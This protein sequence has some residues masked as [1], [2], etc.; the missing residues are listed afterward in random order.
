MCHLATVT[1][2]VA[3]VVLSFFASAVLGAG[4]LLLNPGAEQGKGDQPSV[5]FAA[6][7]PADGLRMN[8]AHDEAHSGAASLAIDNEHEY[9]QI[10]SNNWM[11]DLQSVPRG[12]PVQLRAAIRTRDADAANVCLQCWD[13]SGKDMLA[14]AST[15]VFRGDQDWIEVNA[16]PVIVP[17]GTAKI[18]VR[19]ALTGKGQAWFDDLQ[20]EVVPSAA[21]ESG[22]TNHSE[23]T[24]SQPSALPAVELSIPASLPGRLVQAIPISRDCMVLAY[25]PEWDYGNVDNIAVANN[26]GGVRTLLAWEP[27]SPDLIQAANRRAYLAIYSRQTTAGGDAAE[28]EVTAYPILDDWPERTSWK[29]QPKTDQAHPTVAKFVAG[30]GWKLLDVTE[31]LRVSAA[32]NRNGVMLT[33]ADQRQRV[34]NWSGYAIVSREGL[35]EWESRHPQLLIV[36][37]DA[38]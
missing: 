31:L 16:T 19:A 25:M 21:I 6:S 26:E 38:P 33:F 1:P 30:D 36:E 28:L 18:T 35:G 29:S 22:A 5:W 9:E 7:V 12:A 20:V 3:L 17:N 14:F 2:G 27:T 4:N 32:A 23:I 8:R 10:V 37:T 24:T 15:P 11:Q 34:A 13:A